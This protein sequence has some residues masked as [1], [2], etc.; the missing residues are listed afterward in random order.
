MAQYGTSPI[1]PSAQQDTL[2]QCKT[3]V[4]S[5]WKRKTNYAGYAGWI[6]AAN[7]N[8]WTIVALV[9]VAARR[10]PVGSCKSWA[11]HAGTGRCDLFARHRTACRRPLIGIIH[12]KAESRQKTTSLRKFSS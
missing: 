6:A 10:L 2:T 4:R 12:A 8:L 1:A 11:G 5:K 9:A 3:K 7:G